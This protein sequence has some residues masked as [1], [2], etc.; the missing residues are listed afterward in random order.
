[1]AK[2]KRQAVASG[3]RVVVALSDT[4]CG[5]R[6]GLCNPE[7]VLEDVDAKGNRY[8]WPVRLT[9]TQAYLWEKYTADLAAVKALAG[10]DEI[11]VLVAGDL[12]QG[13]KHPQSLMSNNLDHQIV[14]AIDVLRPWLSN[15]HN[16]R[17]MRLVQGTAAHTMDGALEP[18]VARTLKAERPEADIGVVFHGLF[19]VNEVTFDVVHKGPYPG[20]RE[21]LRGNVAR[22][23]L[24]S[25]MLREL[26]DGREPPRV[27]IRAHYH[28]YEQVPET[29]M[30]HGQEAKSDLYLLPSYCGM[31]LH[32]HSATQGTSW[33]S[34]G[35]VAFETEPGGKLGRVHPF[36]ETL[37][38]RTRE[39]L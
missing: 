33:Q 1:M 7:T 39:V 34:H 21:W 19:S 11:V 20:S 25:M 18:M 4:H 31:D 16:A 36:V 22:L 3:R 32:G 13:I 9:E 38:L 2:P 23:A 37:D 8:S 14:I 15:G 24:R 28:R 10:A 5:H 26:L 27:V 35:L 12:T 6:L 17:V 29:V 30:H